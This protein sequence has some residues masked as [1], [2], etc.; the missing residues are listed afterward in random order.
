MLAVQQ[1]KQ[2]ERY[3]AQVQ[4]GTILRNN[5]PRVGDVQ[6]QVSD[7]SGG[8]AIYYTTRKNRIRLDRIFD[9]GRVRCAGWSVVK[10]PETTI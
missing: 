7:V 2:M 4:A 10:Q 3:M 8:F 9:D 6:I 5:D 1:T